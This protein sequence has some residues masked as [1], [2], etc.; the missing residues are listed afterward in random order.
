MHPRSRN[1]SKH[2]PARGEGFPLGPCGKARL[3]TFSGAGAAARKGVF[4]G[5]AGKTAVFPVHRPF[6]IRDLFVAGLL[7]FGHHVFKAAAVADYRPVHI[8]DEKIKKSDSSTSIE[9]S[10]CIL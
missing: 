3:R 2:P 6:Q 10:H 8:A 4:G 5:A 1:A 9:P 7:E